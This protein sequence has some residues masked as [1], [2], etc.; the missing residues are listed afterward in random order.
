MAL[1]QVITQ[2][3]TTLR[4]DSG[5]G[6]DG[7]LSGFALSGTESN[8]VTG[9]AFADMTSPTPVIS[10]ANS[11]TDSPI[12]INVDFGEVVSGFVVGDIVVSNANTAN[13]INV[14]GQVYTLDLYTVSDGAVTA[15]HSGKCRTGWKC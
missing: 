9:G 11:G 7:T 10:T 15:D 4:D 6:N 1:L 8:W 13:F 14:D 3:I 2:P 12:T 5:S